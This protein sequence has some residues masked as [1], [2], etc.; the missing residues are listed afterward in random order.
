MYS[1]C[2]NTCQFLFCRTMQLWDLREGGHAKV[3]LHT[4]LR[5]L[6]ELQQCTRALC[7]PP[8]AFRPYRQKAL[9]KRNQRST[10]HSYCCFAILNCNIAPGKPVT[11]LFA[12]LTRQASRRRAD[13][14]TVN[15]CMHKR[16]NRTYL[17]WVCNDRTLYLSNPYQLLPCTFCAL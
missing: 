12:T 8:F 10:R 11:A 13:C 2:P 5:N 16:T 3:G 15:T 17:T 1:R 14:E 4:S 6:R 9:V 7:I